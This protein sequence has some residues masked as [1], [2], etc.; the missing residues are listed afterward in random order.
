MMDKTPVAVPGVHGGCGVAMGF[1][2][3][4]SSREDSSF[5]T[6]SQLDLSQNLESSRNASASG[7]PS[8]ALLAGPDTDTCH[9][10]Q[11]SRGGSVGSFQSRSSLPNRGR[12]ISSRGRPSLPGGEDGS[13]PV[14]LNDVVASSARSPPRVSK[15]SASTP[16]S[17]EAPLLSLFGSFSS[18]TRSLR[19]QLFGTQDTFR[20]QSVAR[21]LGA[22]A[23]ETQARR[24][25]IASSVLVDHCRDAQDAIDHL[26]LLVRSRF[27]WLF[28]AASVVLVY[29]G[30]FLV[31]LIIKNT[32]SDG[33]V[34]SE[35]FFYYAVAEVSPMGLLLALIFQEEVLYFCSIRGLQHGDTLQHPTTDAPGAIVE[36][37]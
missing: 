10:A 9:S 20:T 16:A 14:S 4:D 7:R 31:Y 1:N 33:W 13:M 37:T 21:L 3:K 26:E 6:S 11:G 15:V 32:L 28:V 17:V 18:A 19:P 24:A 36:S 34:D 35:M 5:V 23:F 8:V 2:F 30:L 27:F 29:R 12:Q 25:S 22:D